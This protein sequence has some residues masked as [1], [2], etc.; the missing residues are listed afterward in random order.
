MRLRPLLFVIVLSL[1]L[2][3]VAQSA[4][5]Q[6]AGEKQGVTI[7]RGLDSATSPVLPSARPRSTGRSRAGA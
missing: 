4:P 2:L 7:V 1:A 3:G 5:A 6:V